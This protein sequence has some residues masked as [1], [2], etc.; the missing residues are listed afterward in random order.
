MSPWAT[1]AAPF[2]RQ[3]GGCD[4]VKIKLKL[5]CV[6]FLLLLLFSM[7]HGANRLLS[8]QPEVSNSGIFCLM[9]MLLV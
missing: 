3:K 9:Y 8:E 2:L 7:E 6:I 5:P 1:E 4:L